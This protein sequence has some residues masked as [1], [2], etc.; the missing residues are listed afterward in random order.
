[1]SIAYIFGGAGFIGT[2][3]V[4]RLARSG[5][6]SQVVSLDIAEPRRPVAG[7]DYVTCDV[8]RPID[9]STLPKA[10]SSHVYNLAAVHRTP[11]HPD[12]D[13]FTTN[14]WGALHV[15]A[16]AQKIAAMRIVFT[17]SIA[18]YGPTEHAVD[19]TSP[20]NPSSAYGKSKLM[21][22]EIHRSLVGRN[23]D[24]QLV[25]VRPAVI[26]GPGEGGNF[27]RLA[28]ALSSGFFVYP[29]RRDTIKSCGY[30]DELLRTMTDLPNEVD[31]ELVFNFCY[32]DRYT[33]EDIC[34]A[35]KAV[36]DL[37]APR[38]MMPRAMTTCLGA[39]G[40]GLEGLGIRVPVNSERIAKLQNS[41]NIVPRV[42]QE[43]NWH[44][45][46]DLE[47]ALGLWMREDPSG[48]FE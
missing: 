42:L 15:G 14:V 32:P 8:R 24:C 31:G 19:E 26:F 33:I 35:F 46:T 37:P 22:E 41:T 48:R 47:S 25:I 27:T 10:D 28:R 40:D 2:R 39:L 38:G 5:S 43:L 4:G 1:V 30:V 3:L 16:F 34:S 18:I 21:A 6:Y 17:S 20:P 44:Y 29:G 9:T 7:V 23:A 13:Y 36:A 12:A 11:G 45:E